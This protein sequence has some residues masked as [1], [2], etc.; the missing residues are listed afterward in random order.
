MFTTSL[1]LEMTD[2]MG[3]DDLR[4]QERFGMRIY[5][6]KMLSMESNGHVWMYAEFLSFSRQQDVRGTKRGK[7][8]VAAVFSCTS[9]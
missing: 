7:M 1:A 9:S 5:N 2:V 3:R 6:W 8:P 4:W